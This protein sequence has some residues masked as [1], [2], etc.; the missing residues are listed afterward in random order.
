MSQ[1]PG[2]QAHDAD[3]RSFANAM[4][5]KVCCEFELGKIGNFVTGCQNFD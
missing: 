1:A 4:F 2:G 5:C 3:E